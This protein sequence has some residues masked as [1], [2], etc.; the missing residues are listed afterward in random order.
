MCRVL[1]ASPEQADR[2]LLK[3]IFSEHFFNV[4]FLDD[5]LSAE[6][7]YTRSLEQQ[8]DMLILDVSESSDEIFQYKTNIVKRHPNIKVILLDNEENFKHIQT[9][10]RCG[11]VDYLVKPLKAEECKSAIH[12]AILA[13]NQVSLLHYERKS[14]TDTIKESAAQMMQYV[15]EHYH[16]EINLDSLARF[17]HLNK[18]Y[19]SRFFKETVGMSFVSYLRHYR[20][21]QAKKLLRTTDLTVTEIAEQVG[22]LDLTYFSRIFKK[23]TNYTPNAFKQVYQGEHVPADIAFAEGKTK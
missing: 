10:I 17:M 20:I 4:T 21:E 22:Y 15:H 6:E 8:P 18:S 19:V 1:L 14:V 12:R 5:A 2:I 13:L 16:E 11:A 7:A 3:Q 9:A 23:E